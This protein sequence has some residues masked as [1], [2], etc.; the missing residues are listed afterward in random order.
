MKALSLKQPWA[1]LVANG[2]KK[3]ELR[4][5]NTNFRGRFL[6]HAS[7][8]PDFDAMKRFGF[9]NLPMGAIVGKANLADVKHYSKKSEL[10]KDK[11]LHLAS[12]DW[13][14]YGFVLENI[15]RV[16]PIKA[17]GSLNFWDF[18]DNIK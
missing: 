1:E 8:I 18:K 14:E 9:D 2:R 15:E 16:E 4:K 13:G 3:I 5:W 7:K 12:S 11:N 17:K 6:I 10:E